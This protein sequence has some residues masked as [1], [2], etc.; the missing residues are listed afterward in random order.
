MWSLGCFTHL[1]PL[2]YPCQ[3]N[4]PEND[5]QLVEVADAML[6]MV[7]RF[8]SRA[9]ETRADKP[10]ADA[11][12]STETICSNEEE[13]MPADEIL[14]HLFISKN[15]GA[16]ISE[17]SRRKKPPCRFQFFFAQRNN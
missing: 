11:I 17:A 15:L 8:L 1:L 5:S 14:Q 7:E 3:F 13:R 6:E 2:R 10:S 9:Q 16:K 12:I 4:D